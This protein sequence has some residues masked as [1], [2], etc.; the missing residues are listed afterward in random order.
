MT[1]PLE[2]SDRVDEKKNTFSLSDLFLC[3][4][5]RHAP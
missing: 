5:K 2:E 1:A 3:E 4:G